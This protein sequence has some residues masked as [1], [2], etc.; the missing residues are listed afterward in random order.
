MVSCLPLPVNMRHCPY[1]PLSITSP[2]GRK[3]Q[4]RSAEDAE[5]GA[6]P[7]QETCAPVFF[8]SA[9]WGWKHEKAGKRHGPH[10]QARL[11]LLDRV[12][13]SRQGVQGELAVQQRKPGTQ[14][15]E[16]ADRRSCKRAL[17]RPERGAV[18][19]R[20][21]REDADHRLRDQWQAVSGLRSAVDP[22]SAR[23]LRI[24]LR[25]RH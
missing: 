11:D 18:E 5:S 14:T 20:G 19:L 21:P 4:R 25:H 23:V 7:R 3:C 22:A 13:L 24:V 6:T 2:W 8:A 1:T 12:L 15:T 9:L 17:D 10:L 16:E